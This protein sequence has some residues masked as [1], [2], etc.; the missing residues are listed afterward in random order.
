MPT[1]KEEVEELVESGVI[2]QEKADRLLD[3]SMA[4]EAVREFDAIK[5]ERDELAS[6]KADVETAP[7]RAKALKDTLGVEW[8]GLTYAEQDFL[9]RNIPT[10]KFTDKEHI[11]QMV[12]QGGIKYEPPQQTPQNLPAA[13]GVVNQAVS[14]GTQGAPVDRA[15]LF[16][17]AKT[18]EEVAQLAAQFP[19]Q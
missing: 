15:A 18:P 1:Y 14:G 9:K 16:A 12:Q 17:G 7:L 5:R 2:T 13:A 10:E 8:E 4:K 6:F 19:P 3:L 11:A